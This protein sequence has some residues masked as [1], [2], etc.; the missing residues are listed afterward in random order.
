MDFRDIEEIK[1]ILKAQMIKAESVI[2]WL[3]FLREKLNC[4]SFL[5]YQNY[6]VETKKALNDAAKC[7]I[8]LMGHRGL[9]LQTY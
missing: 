2:N 8:F 7:L 1:L 6:T 9:E 3:R 5:L 4:I